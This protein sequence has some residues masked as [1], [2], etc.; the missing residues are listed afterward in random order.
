[1][2]KPD[3]AHYVRLAVDICVFRKVDLDIQVLLIQRRKYPFQGS[4]ALPGGRLE[5]DESLDQCAVRE[6]LEETGLHAISIRHFANFSEPHRDP[7][8]RTVAAAYI[9]RVASDAEVVAG[10]DAS[11]AKWFSTSDLPPLA[12]D[13]KQILQIALISLLEASGH[14]DLF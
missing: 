12:F 3:T 7:R 9:A 14:N 8:E 10:S 1:M 2:K 4:W 13:H 11:M 5:A 6:L